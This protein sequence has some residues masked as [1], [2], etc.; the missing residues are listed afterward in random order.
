MTD[1]PN[2]DLYLNTRTRDLR[3][4]TWDLKIVS[5][6]ANHPVSGFPLS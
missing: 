1:F 5:A 6:P 4:E 2:L 3:A